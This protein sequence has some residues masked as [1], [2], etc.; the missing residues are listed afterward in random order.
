MA[1][2]W[3]SD[4][5]MDI[6]DAIFFSKERRISDFLWGNCWECYTEGKVDFGYQHLL[7]VQQWGFDQIYLRAFFLTQFPQ[8]FC[9]FIRK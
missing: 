1:K 6:C 5:D 4:C 9:R 3:D 8:S 2:L 7:F